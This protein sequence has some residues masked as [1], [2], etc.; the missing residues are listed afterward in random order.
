MD[1]R[2]MVWPV[3]GTGEQLARTLQEASNAANNAMSGQGFEIID[4]YLRWAGDQIRMLQGQLTAAD[5]DRLITTPR[6]WATMADPMS[7]ST[8][9]NVIVEELQHR[10]RVLT[11]AADAVA[12]EAAAWRPL[13]GRY[14][15]FVV[16][17]TNYWME[18]KA[19]LSTLDWH[20]A[21]AEATGSGQPAM[22]EELRIVVPLLVVDELDG[23]SHN[24]SKRPKVTGVTQFLYALLADQPGLPR[25]VREETPDRGAVTIQLLFDPLSHLRL[26]NNDDELIE[27][28]VVLRDFLGHPHRQ[29]FFLTH[30]ASAAFRAATAGLM[31]RRLPTLP[32]G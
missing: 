8:M 11:A 16:V 13:D 26:P 15:N 19:S 18:Q 30:D 1:R 23:H 29:V 20:Q 3:A 17:D 28:A 6:Y 24:A 9:V 2:N 5:L 21:L 4:N 10:A 7:V 32:R 12:N 25:Q 31:A 27:R 14:S 22:Q